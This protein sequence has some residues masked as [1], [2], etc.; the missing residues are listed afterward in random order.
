MQ[1][2]VGA[3]IA[4]RVLYSLVNTAP[5]RSP[6]HLLTSTVAPVLRKP[7]QQQARQSV[8]RRAYT[9]FWHSIEPLFTH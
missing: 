1:N 7:Y 3:T 5:P 6:V 8:H 4:Q 2:V 9:A